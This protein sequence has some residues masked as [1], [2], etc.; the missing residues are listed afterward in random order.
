MHGTLGAA[1]RVDL[2]LN[3]V[4]TI[5]RGP[6]V[7]VA[8]RCDRNEICKSAESFQHNVQLVPRRRFNSN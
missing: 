5:R 2:E 4:P 6:F 1:W 3:K 8:R 7:S